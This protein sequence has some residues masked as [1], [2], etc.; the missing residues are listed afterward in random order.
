MV[1]VFQSI[2]TMNQLYINKQSVTTK[3]KQQR[4]VNRNIPSSKYKIYEIYADE[5]YRNQRRNN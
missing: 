2:K 4:K 1:A 5:K 3:E